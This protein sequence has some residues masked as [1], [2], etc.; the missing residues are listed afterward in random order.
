MK[1]GIRQLAKQFKVKE[2]ELKELFLFTG[3]WISNKT[4]NPKY[5]EN[6]MI[7]I[8]RVEVNSVRRLVSM[9]VYDQ[10]FIIEKLSELILEYGKI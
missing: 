8:K 7:E 9:V 6:G 4:P 10:E 3:I 5:I 1:M 2:R